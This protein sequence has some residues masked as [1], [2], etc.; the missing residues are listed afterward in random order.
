MTNWKQIRI[1]FFFF[2]FELVRFLDRFLK[3]PSFKI[4]QADGLTF[5]FQND[6]LPLFF[7]GLLSFLVGM[8]RTTRRFVAR[9][10]DN[11]HFLCYVLIS[12][13]VKSCAGNNSHTV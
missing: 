4:E 12:P 5:F 2:F 1:C 11:S 9:K 13:K 6:I 3:N 8:K 10:R 7:S